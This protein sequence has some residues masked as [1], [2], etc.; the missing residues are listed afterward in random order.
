MG[1]PDTPATLQSVQVIDAKSALEEKVSSGEKVKSTDFRSD[2][3]RAQDVKDSLF[4]SQFGKCCYCENKRS[5]KRELDAEHF[6]PKAGVSDEHD[7]PGYW[8][9][10][11]EWR[12]L[13]YAC[14]PCNQECK[15]NR[16]PISGTRSLGPSGC[17]EDESPLLIN[18]IEENPEDYIGFDWQSA[19]GT[20]V[21]ATGLNERGRETI[22]I[23]GLDR[24]ELQEERAEVVYILQ[25]AA[26]TMIAAKHLFKTEVI[27][28]LASKIWDL[29][30]SNRRFASFRRAFFR[31]HGLGEYVAGD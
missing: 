8:W 30:S 11:Y 7:H 15:G 9:L 31:A 2:Y 29:T 13:L 1:R 4:E 6:R 28:E 23:A 26:N 17:L 10:V 20:L 12:N 16:F 18:P 24:S 19:Y 22:K 14:K 21:K 27:P 25:S 5:A 3:W